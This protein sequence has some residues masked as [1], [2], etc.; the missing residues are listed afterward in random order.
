MRGSGAAGAPAGHSVGAPVNATAPMP[1][2]PPIPMPS[3]HG[4]LVISE[5]MI[6]PKS[7]SDTAGEWF[8]LY[9]PNDYELDLRGCEIDDGG[10]S[11]HALALSLRAKPHA[12][13]TI[14][15]QHGPGF[16][17]DG[18][19]SLSLTNSADSLALRCA[20]V[21]LDRVSYDKAAGYPVTSGASLALDPGRL[22]ATQNDVAEAWCAGSTSYG[23]ELGTPGG[24]NPPCAA[25]N[26]DGD[27]DAGEPSGD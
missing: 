3:K 7:S 25:Q 6:D 11:P 17:P 27:G 24:A 12:Y 2:V 18:T 16:T 15:R 1:T 13:V 9:N 14:A 21:E 23:P 8:E 22:D 19:A 10:K 5:L 4:E 20:G 26:S